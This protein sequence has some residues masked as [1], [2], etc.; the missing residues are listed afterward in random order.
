M[1]AKEELR[2]IR[3]IDIEV[4]AL[5]E[6]LLE[7][8]TKLTHITPI[9]SDMPAYHGDKDKMT[10]GIC[11]LIE[12]KKDYNAKINELL[13]YRKQ[14][15]KIIDQIPDSVYRTIL[16]ERYFKYKNFENVA[17]TI[18]YSYHH[19]VRKHGHALQA[20]ELVKSG[21][22]RATITVVR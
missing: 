13:D 3:E 11:K 18:C 4:S 7:V 22:D 6:S 10:S 16:K 21:Q 8:D 17:V 14:C 2:Q 15:E 9:L 5:E 12:L 19:T 1:T 20:Y